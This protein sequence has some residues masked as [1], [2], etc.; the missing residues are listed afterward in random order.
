MLTRMTKMKMAIQRQGTTNIT[1][2]TEAAARDS[3]AGAHAKTD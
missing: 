1:G 3:V 2:L